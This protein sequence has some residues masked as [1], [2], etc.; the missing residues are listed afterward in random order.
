MLLTLIRLPT[1]PGFTDGFLLLDG[2]FYCHTVEDEIRPAKDP[3]R[4][5]IP[6]GSYRVTVE[7]SP[8]FTAKLGRPVELPRLHDVPGFDGVLIHGGN[9]A[10]DSLGC[11]LV[12]MHRIKPGEIRGSM[13]LDLTQRL[14]RTKEEI[15]LN[16]LEAK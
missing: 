15:K 6:K 14:K 16:I 11:V 9:T 5:A 10:E 3:G 8:H 1:R 7:P 2:V 12:G 13:S 4:T